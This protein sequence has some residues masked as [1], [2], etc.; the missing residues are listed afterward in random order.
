MHVHVD[1]PG[2]RWV[3]L[4][5][6]GDTSTFLFDHAPRCK[7]CWTG[8]G[9]GTQGV[10][11]ADWHR[12]ACPTCTEVELRSGDCL[13]FY[14]GPDRGVTH[15]M[16]STHK[17]T[18]PTELPRWCQGGRVSCQVRMT[19]IHQNYEECGAYRT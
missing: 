5:S 7:R 14:A 12:V 3:S 2:T 19:E 1:K 15:G 18:A 17:G 8:G 16:L 9:R 6:L 4:L 11:W 13:P 10:K